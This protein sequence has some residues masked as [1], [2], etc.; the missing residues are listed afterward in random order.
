MAANAARIEL[1]EVSALDRPCII[2]QD[3]NWSMSI[4]GGAQPPLQLGRIGHVR[5]GAGQRIA[6][7]NRL[8]QRSLCAANHRYLRP[9][10]CE[11]GR[12]RA[13][14]AAAATSD[15]NMLSRER[16]PRQL[17]SSNAST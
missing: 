9:G 10:A 6:R 7:R 5:P 2:D 16:Q 4:L 15:D 14:N 11:G 8:P 12:D 3:G 17:L 13:A 1:G